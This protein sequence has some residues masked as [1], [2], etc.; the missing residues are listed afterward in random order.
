MTDITPPRTGLHPRATLRDQLINT[1]DIENIYQELQQIWGLDFAHIRRLVADLD[2][3]QTHGG[4]VDKHALLK[5][6]LFVA[7]TYDTAQA[8][9]D[10]QLLAFIDKTARERDWNIKTYFADL[11]LELPASLETHFDLIFTDPP[12]SPAGVKLFLQRNIA[13]PFD[14]L[15]RLTLQ[16]K[17]ELPI[18]AYPQSEKSG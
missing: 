11:R 2:E 9:I 1:P 4:P 10:E 5:R 8:H 17:A 3:W 6:A 15:L 16:P 7:T 13:T 18:S 12:Y 14:S